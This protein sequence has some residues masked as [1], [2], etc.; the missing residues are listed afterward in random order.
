MI[1]VTV[2]AL[3][4]AGI[5][6]SF[7]LR[8]ER[9][10]EEEELVAIE[11]AVELD[12]LHLE[13]DDHVT[14]AWV[15]QYKPEQSAGGYTLDLYRRRVPFVVDM[16]S[17][18]VHVWPKVRAV[19]RARLDSEGRLAVIGTDNLI[20]EYDWDGNLR[21]YYRLADEGDFPHHDLIK[22][23]NG[24]FMVLATTKQESQ[25]CYLQ[26]VNRKKKVVWE[27]R[28]LDHEDAFPTWD[29]ES[30]DPTHFNSIHELPPN[31]WFDAGDTRFRPGNLLVSAR[32]LS[33]IFVIDKASKEV[34]WQYSKGLDYQHE[35]TMIGKD[36]LGAG[37]ILVFNNG[38]QDLNAYRRSLVQAIDPSTDEVV[39]EYG[40]KFFFSS[41]A[42][43]VQK[44][45]GANLAI[46]SSHGGR[47]FEMTPD[48][49]VVWEW[50]PSYMPMR[51]ERLPYDH[52]PQLA[53]LPI[54][55]DH[56]VLLQGNEKPYVDIDLYRF[57]LDGDFEVREIAGESRR[58]LKGRDEC[59]K[60]LLPPDPRLWVEFGIDVDRLQGRRLD[61]RFTLTIETRRRPPEVLIDQ[62]LSSDSEIPWRGREILLKKYASQRVTMCV[63]TEAE[64]EME[65]PLDMVAWGNPLVRS[66]IQHP[67]EAPVKEK[68]TDQERKLREQQLKALGYV[69]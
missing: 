32:H 28:A 39:W 55:E 56:E 33:T 6:F 27:W 60:L 10:R 4:A 31:R 49:E 30:E 29:A 7:H 65:N 42:G 35:A 41:V 12:D 20:K 44:L 1:L 26:E 13:L 37:W 53:A 46:N 2:V 17:R 18:I 3:I 62:S 19:G 16:N 48:R 64:G 38:R 5:L 50:V 40:S 9:D 23:N 8:G 57:A 63:A 36:D 22:L 52:C 59:R 15:R 54:P 47:V 14:T 21:W 45:P 58:L 67:R 66:R 24:N 51:V 69:N 25:T 34:V 61:A 43:T 68:I 11:A